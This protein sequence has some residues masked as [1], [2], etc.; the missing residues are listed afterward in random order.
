MKKFII[1]SLALFAL[2]LTVGCKKD[3]DCPEGKVWDEEAEECKAESTD[4]ALTKEQCEAKASEGYTW[5]EATS[6]CNPPVTVEETVHTITNKLAEALTVTSGDVSAS[7]AQ[8]EC[9]N[10]KES[11]F[12]ALVLSA[13]TTFN[14]DN[15]NKNEDGTDKTDDDCEGKAAN[16]YD[17]NPAEDKT[18]ATPPERPQPAG[19]SVSEAAGENCKDLAAAASNDS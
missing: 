7:L 9:A 16:N 8:N 15:G 1:M 5:D 19:L 17:V 12:P 11:Q 14:C 6:N 4:T 10:V 2:A 18:T 3:K 13:G